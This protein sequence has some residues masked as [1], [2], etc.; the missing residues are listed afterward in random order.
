M[1]I[2]AVR[3]SK[4]TPTEIARDAGISR[5]AVSEMLN[6]RVRG[7]IMSWAKVLDAAGVEIGWRLKET[8]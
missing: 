7:S 1:F 5:Q 4:K 8:T 6:G 3:S 2:D